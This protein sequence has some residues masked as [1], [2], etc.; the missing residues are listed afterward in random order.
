MA[1]QTGS[2]TDQNDLLNLFAT[3]A[4]DNGWTQNLL[5]DDS[6]K[7]AGDTFTGR[8]LHLQKT[9]NG[10][11]CY[12]NLRSCSN[13][14]VFSY[15]SYDYVT[16]ICV[17]GSTGFDSGDSWDLQ[18][19][20]TPFYYGQTTSSGGNIDKIPET[21]GTYTF[22]ASDS[23][24]SME[25]L[26]ESDTQDHRFLTV[27]CTDLGVPIYS[28]SGSWNDFS[29]SARESRSEYMGYSGGEPSS[30]SSAAL[31][32]D[33][34]YVMQSGKSNASSTRRLQPL[35]DVYGTYALTIISGSVVSPYIAYSP[36]SFRGNAPLPPFSPCVVQGTAY[37]LTPVGTLDGIR[38]INMTNYSNGQE[39]TIGA[40]TYKCFRVFNI[41]P[42]GVAFLK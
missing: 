35:L 7:Y 14:R 11:V 8:R 9:I 28:T 32:S 16:G 29:D 2:Y 22:Y 15:T 40:D 1:Y 10:T 38:F 39:I 37:Q 3:W 12:F 13:Q 5:A 18:T 31:L 26:S 34:W 30:G 36:D 23:S 41:N 27:G 17:N 33:G 20:Y 25:I 6:S 21:G 42:S 19:G 4:V 24:L